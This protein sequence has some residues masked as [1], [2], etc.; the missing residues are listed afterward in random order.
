[1][2]MSVLLIGDYNV[3]AYEYRILGLYYPN[4]EEYQIV[5]SNKEGYQ[6]MLSNKEEY[7]I[8]LSILMMS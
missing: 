7:W 3:E 8:M 6:I 1:M 5:L 4:K 2:M